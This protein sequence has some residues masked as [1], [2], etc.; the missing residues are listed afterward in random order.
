MCPISY[1]QIMRNCKDPRAHRY[2]M[3]QYAIS[4]GIKPA[5]REFGTSA[6]VARKWAQTLQRTRL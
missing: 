3:V 6:I 2:Q 5:A 1:Y 4:R